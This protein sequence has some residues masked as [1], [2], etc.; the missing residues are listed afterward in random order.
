MAAAEVDHTAPVAAAHTD[1]MPVVLEVA[2]AVAG[3]NSSSMVM[4][5]EV[6]VELA[7]RKDTAIAQAEEEDKA[8]VR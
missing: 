8:I 1:Y 4:E 2:V 3:K 6:A 5:L 7:N